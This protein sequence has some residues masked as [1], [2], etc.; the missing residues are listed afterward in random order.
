MRVF[1]FKTPK[2]YMPDGNSMV[3]VINN[4]DAKQTE[5]EPV[6]KLV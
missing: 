2:S 3:C 4:P 6:E 5:V 1:F